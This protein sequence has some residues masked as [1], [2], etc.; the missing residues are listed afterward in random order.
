MKLILAQNCR[1]RWQIENGIRIGKTILPVMWVP[2]HKK[3]GRKEL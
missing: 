2:M 3:T 1:K